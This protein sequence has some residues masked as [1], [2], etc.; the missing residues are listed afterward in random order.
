MHESS[1]FPCQAGK[2]PILCSWPMWICLSPL[3]DTSDVRGV[4]VQVC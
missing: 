1:D 3:Q 4:T 2:G